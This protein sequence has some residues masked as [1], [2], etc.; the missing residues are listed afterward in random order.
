VYV[1]R[2][3]GNGHFGAPTFELA[4]FG[5]GAGG[6]TSDDLYPRTL[7]DVNADGRA[8][9]VGFGSAG[10]YTSLATGG[11]H[12]A[13]PAFTDT[14]FGVGAGGWSS[15]NTYPRQLADVNADGKADVVGFGYGGVHVSQSEFI[16]I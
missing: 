14:A 10:V 13:A 8:D 7:A 4:A 2:A 5:A 9:I 6:W 3:T 16:S 11:G 1:S 12:F 15:Y